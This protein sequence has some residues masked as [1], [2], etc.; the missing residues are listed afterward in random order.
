MG[1][2]VLFDLQNRGNFFPQKTYIALLDGEGEGNLISKVN[3]H[4]FIQLKRVLSVCSNCKCVPL[5]LNK[6][7]QLTH[8]F[9][10]VSK[11]GFRLNFL[12]CRFLKPRIPCIQQIWKGDRRKKK[13]C[14]KK[15]K[16]FRMITLISN[17]IYTINRIGHVQKYVLT[18][19][20]IHTHID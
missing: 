4:G 13:Y 12:K 1:Q 2:A 14:S 11:I 8:S 16:F 5:C 19:M 6:L 15:L 10:L 3:Y 17:G 18:L 7:K 9:F 20:Y